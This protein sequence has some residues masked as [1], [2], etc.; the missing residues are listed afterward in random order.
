M[1]K[2]KLEEVEILR[3]IA[4]LA[5]VMQH[6]IAGIFYQPG[7][8]PMALNVGTTLLGLIRFAVPLFVFITGVVLF[9]NY[10]AKVN[11]KDFLRKRFKQVIIPYLAWTVFYYVWVGFLS[12]VEATST[13]NQLADVIQ[14]AF[15]GKASYHLWFMVMI[16]PFY[17]LFP[18]CKLLISKN[19]KWPIN[20]AVAATIFV[21]NMLL[22]YALSKGMITSDNPNLG[23]IFNYLDRNFLFWIFYFMLGG[24]V[25]LYY[26]CWKTFV[27]K[28]WVL[29]LLLLG[30]SMYYIC[31]KIFRI[32]EGVTDNPYLFSANVTAPLK[33]FMMVTILLLLVLVFYLAEKIA[34][35]RSRPANLLRTFGKYS[36]GAYLIH[37]FAL[38]IVNNL[39]LSYLGV[40]GVFAQ[41]IISFVLCSLLSLILCVGISRVKSSFGEVLV[42]RV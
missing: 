32:N 29:S 37:A 33:P 2:A 9:Y 34:A 22:V 39:V 7:L 1:R 15:T 5:V 31:V 30:I 35:N 36:F 19:R 28:T 12:G 25:G 26:D 3:G 23:F 42:G 6:T 24:L 27:H 14:L 4:F 17:V 18:L 10:D 8:S 38:N 40:L 21:I 41:T 16:I 11:Y 13:W 20:L